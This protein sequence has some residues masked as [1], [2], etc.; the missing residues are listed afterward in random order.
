MGVKA[1]GKKKGVVMGSTGA[2]RQT[3]TALRGGSMQTPAFRQINNLPQTAQSASGG[4]RLL[5][6]NSVH[7]SDGYFFI[8]FSEFKC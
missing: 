3:A 1:W 5:I 6:G 2:R 4:E 7:A 8:V